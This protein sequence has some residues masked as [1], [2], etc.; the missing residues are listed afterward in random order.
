MATRRLRAFKRWMKSK[1]FEWSD[2]LEFVDTPKEGIAVRALCELKE[3][4]VVAKMPKEACLTIKTSGACGIIEDAGLEGLLGLAFAIMY[5]RSL[6]GDSPWAGYLQLLTYQECVPLVWTLN[7]VNELLRGTE[8]HQEVQEDKALMYEDW[9]ERILPLL[10]LAP[11]KL[12]PVFFGIEQYFAARSLISSRSF[13]IDDYHG[14]GMVPLADMFNHKT[15][16]EDVHF[17]AT[18]SNYESDNDVDGNNSDESITD[19]EALAQNSSIDATDF[20]AAHVSDSECSSDI[21]GDPSMLEMIMIKDV[22]SGAEVFNTYGL[23]GNAALLHR[24]GFTE[25]DNLY[26]IVNIDLEL[27]L[28]WCSSLFSS[29][30]GRARVS[31]WRRLGYS[32][33][34]IQNSEYFE[35]SFN[36]EP[37]VELPI[38]LYIMLLSDKAYHELDLSV[39]TAGKRHESSKTTL[40]Y[41]KIFPNKASNMSKKFLLTNKVCDALISLADMRES[42]YGSESIEDHVEALERCSSVSAKKVYHSLVLR[43]CERKILQKLRNYASQPLNKVTNHSTERKLRRTTKKR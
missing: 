37:Q 26:D 20:D 43:I 6:G 11:S 23:L 18:P 41:D 9:K 33:C 8:L 29:R 30:H 25:Q 2:A 27:V 24:Y 13:E 39:S 40:L 14:S 4:D 38:L 1:G 3:G 15:G 19:E 36:G 31:L 17:T 22:S 7:E 16:A 32:A 34:G 5:E 21:G 35:I 42:L 10:N 28:K 12:N